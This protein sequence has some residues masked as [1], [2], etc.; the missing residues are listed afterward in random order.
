[1]R[2][3]TNVVYLGWGLVGGV[4]VCASE[5]MVRAGLRQQCGSVRASAGTS[6]VGPVMVIPADADQRFNSM[7]ITGAGACR[8]L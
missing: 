8:S 4:G 7:S 6:T 5:G 2:P 1:M 3:M